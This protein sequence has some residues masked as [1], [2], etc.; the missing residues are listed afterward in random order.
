MVQLCGHNKFL[1]AWSERI[2]KKSQ[3]PLAGFLDD[4]CSI[5]HIGRK[6]IQTK[7][8]HLA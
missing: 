5:E 2:A 7:A 4:G 8:E 3:Q 6:K 1:R